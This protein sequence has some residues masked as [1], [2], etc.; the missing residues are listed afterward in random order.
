MGVNS[1][2]TGGSVRGVRH[3][4]T[5]VT[6]ICGMEDKYVAAKHNSPRSIEF[7]RVE[8]GCIDTIPRNAD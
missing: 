8:Q 2:G 6:M 5:C 7:N 1:E 4:M 3:K